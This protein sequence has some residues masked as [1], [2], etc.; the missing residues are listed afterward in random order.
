MGGAVTPAHPATGSTAAAGAAAERSEQPATPSKE[1]GAARPGKGKG[2][3]RQQP[4]APADA[5][6]AEGGGAAAAAAAGDPEGVQALLDRAGFITRLS[7]VCYGIPQG[8][9]SNTAGQPHWYRA[10]RQQLCGGG[11]RVRA[12]ARRASIPCS[13]PGPPQATSRACAPQPSSTPHPSCWPWVWCCWLCRAGTGVHRC[14]CR[15]YHRPC[16]STALWWRAAGLLGTHALL[17]GPTPA[18]LVPASGGRARDRQRRLHSRRQPAVQ[19]GHAA[20]WVGGWVGGLGICALL[21]ALQL[22]LPL[23]LRACGSGTQ[24]VCLPSVAAL[25]PLPAPPLGPQALWAPPSACPTSTPATASPSVWRGWICWGREAAHDIVWWGG[26]A[27]G[28]RTGLVLP[29]AGAA[30]RS[31][32]RCLPSLAL[33]TLPQATWPRLTWRARAWCP[34]VEWAS[35][36]TVRAPLGLAARAAALV[37]PCRARGLPQAAAS[38]KKGVQTRLVP[39]GPQHP[40]PA[41]P[42]LPL[43]CPRRR[44]ARAAHQPARGRHRRHDARAAGGRADGGHPRGRGR[45]G[46]HQVSGLGVLRGQVEWLG[47]LGFMLRCAALRCAALCYRHRAWHAAGHSASRSAPRSAALSLW[48]G[49]LC[50]S[51]STRRQAEPAGPGGSAGP[52][53]EVDRAAGHLLARGPPSAGCLLSAGT[54]AA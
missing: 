45:G 29:S 50:L 3:A 52:G 24:Q 14:H 48:A 10:C 33:H 15:R 51:I 38:G 53:H 25:H 35:T 32:S 22:L 23:Q 54:A 39:S 17:S 40:A 7:D 11:S 49:P 47:G 30:Q 36:S 16:C 21:P 41:F 12:H 28:R 4:A 37:P 5:S 46:G 34:L 9:R 26:R 8:V 44:R 19:R 20:G 18:P 43:L 13:L 2:K 27:L 31:S 42:V 6:A 1:A